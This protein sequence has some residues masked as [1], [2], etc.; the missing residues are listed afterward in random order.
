MIGKVL[1]LVAT[2]MLLH[3]ESRLASYLGHLFM[4]SDRVPCSCVLYL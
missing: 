1:A 2:C 3:G 4:S